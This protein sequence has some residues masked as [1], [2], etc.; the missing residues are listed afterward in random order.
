MFGKL[1]ILDLLVILLVLG[2]VVLGAFQLLKPEDVAE[3]SAA[4][5]VTEVVVIGA[6]PDFIEELERQEL[7]GKALMSG[8]NFTGDIIEEIWL[9]DFTDTAQTDDGTLVE[10]VDPTL[11]NVVFRIRSTVSPDSPS[12]MVGGQEAR[13]GRSLTIKTETFSATGSIRY[14]EIEE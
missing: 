5:M 3:V 6:E 11:K 7:A 9:E 10:T 4:E 2:A 8:N 1:H 13:V 12:L 14:M